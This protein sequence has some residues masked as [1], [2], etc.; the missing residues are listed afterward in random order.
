[1]EYPNDPSLRV[2]NETI[3]RSLFIQACGTLKEELVKAPAAD[4]PLAAR[5]RSR[6][7]PRPDR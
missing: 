6:A 3:Y 5:Q 7:L 1:M 4:P 2:S